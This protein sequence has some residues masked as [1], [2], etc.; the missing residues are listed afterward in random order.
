MSRHLA[1][2]LLSSYMDEEVTPAQLRLVEGHLSDC[3]DCRSTLAG[4][5]AV[6]A[7]VRR[8]EAVAPPPT[9]SPAVER[10]ARLASLEEPGWFRLEDGLKRWAGQPVLAPAFAI[11]LALGAILY[12]FAFGVSKG[13]RHTTR[14]VVATAPSEEGTDSLGKH[15]ELRADSEAPA[16]EAIPTD[17]DP[18]RPA[19]TRA[20]S[21]LPATAAQAA[22]QAVDGRQE[23]NS[24]LEPV[25][26]EV[27]ARAEF[28]QIA[29]SSESA[30]SARVP[31]VGAD[32]LPR[33]SEKES[34]AG[35]GA[36][37]EVR[38]LAAM[39]LESV[40]PVPGIAKASSGDGASEVRELAGRTFVREEGI[41]VEVG[42]QGEPVVEILDLR[43]DSTRLGIE[44][45]AFR[46]LER[47]RL[48]VDDRVVEV[49]YP[50]A[51]PRD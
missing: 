37:G 17:R 9:L 35:T 42:L 16:S 1:I 38:G 22:G 29:E 2:E 10:R 5:R 45:S 43:L 12:L 4:L 49:I 19:R 13:G 23:L 40:S 28:T 3:N 50:E 21:D 39:Q 14:L 7:G 47:V 36:R 33:S 6:A 24:K 18:V 31:P 20:V 46:G 48:R 34:P 41:W 27:A 51:A 32:R 15:N 30:T 26:P 11:I 44:L 25:L 8:L